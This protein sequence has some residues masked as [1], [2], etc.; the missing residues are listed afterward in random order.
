MIIL[1]TEIQS[2]FKEIAERLWMGHASIMVGAGFSK[3]SIN[4]VNPSKRPPDWAEL[5]DAFYEKLYN[6]KP[7]NGVKYLNLLKLSEEFEAAFGRPALEQFISKNIADNE[8][9]P[10][11]LHRMLIELPWTDVFTTNY[12]TLLE[13]SCKDVFSRKYDIV[14][15]QTDLVYS[16]KPRIIKLHG[17][18]PSEKPFIITE[19]DYRLYPKKYSP[20]VNTVQQSLLENTLCLIGFSGDDPNFLQWVGW[21]NDNIGKENAPKIYLVGVLN[22]SET[23]KKL[24]N[25]KNIIPVDISLCREINGD[26]K[27]GLE[28][29][30]NYLVNQQNKKENLEWPLLVDLKTIQSSTKKADVTLL[31]NEWAECRKKFP[32]WFILPQENRG[33]LWRYTERHSFNTSIFKHL[34]PFIELDY[35][36]ELNWRLE[37]CLFPIWNNLAPLFQEILNRYNFFPEKLLDKKEI[38]IDSWN[39][40]LIDEVKYKNYWIDLSLSLLRFYREEG[41][42]NEWDSIYKTLSLIVEHLSKEQIAHF[43]YERVLNY[44]FKMQYSEAKKLLDEW[45]QN[46][47]PV[48]WNAKRAMLMTEFG[49]PK[50]ALNLLELCLLQIRKKLNLSPIEEDYTWVSQESYVMLHLS[51]VHENIRWLEEK[52][53]NHKKEDF[54]ERWN[55]LLKYKCDPWGEK[56]YFDLVLGQPYILRNKE[57][58]RKEF[59]IGQI[60][61]TFSLGRASHETV[62]SYTFL[63]YL[64]ELAIPLSTEV[65]NFGSNT[66]N[67]ALERIKHVSPKWVMGVLNRHRDDKGVEVFFDRMQLKMLPLSLVDEYVKKYLYILNISLTESKSSHINR[68]FFNKIPFILSRLCTKCSESLR[69]EIFKSYAKLCEKGLVIR[70]M[71]ILLKNLVDSSTKSTLTAAIKI[72]FDVPV[73][74]SKDNPLHLIEP[75]TILDPENVGQKINIEKKKIEY[76]F[77]KASEISEYSSNSIIRLIFLFR[78]G[79]LNKKQVTR[80]FNIIWQNVDSSSGFPKETLFYNF[81]FIKWPHPQYLNVEKLFR[82]YINDNNFNIQSANLENGIEEISGNDK[83][84]EELLYSSKTMYHLDGIVWDLEDLEIILSKCEIWWDKDKQFLMKRKNVQDIYIGSQYEEFIK[85]FKNLTNILS[86]VIGYHRGKINNESIKRIELLVKDMEKFSIPVLKVKA[87][88]GLYKN[89]DTYLSVVSKA[90]ISNDRM[91]QV[92]ALDSIIHSIYYY[93]QSRDSKKINE[94]LTLLNAPLQWKIEIIIGDIFDIVGQIIIYTKVDISILEKNLYATLTDVLNMSKFSERIVFE[95]YLL[96]RRQA[97]ELASKLYQIHVNSNTT[98][99]NILFDWKTNSEDDNEFGDIK[100]RW[101]KYST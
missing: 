18:L 50:E 34:S 52:K 4:S 77:E 16:N 29:F 97:V 74:S 5:G 64:E 6:K 61:R 51:L 73:V 22:L 79:Q 21:I 95:D 69:I 68:A 46:N 14:I 56:K 94:I 58:A 89:I 70:K 99:P 25:K 81:A 13:R 63:R 67:G 60:T 88:F 98:P 48:L 27:K 36:F 80:L 83:Y 82:K 86:N 62:L 59:R 1:P 35:I 93:T 85:R 72:L 26:H 101:E 7:N 37:K 3:N 10:T 17:S 96:L 84:S 75:F 30:I 87:A 100:N 12:D 54:N 41:F 45:P 19:E 42:S 44:I 71:D 65:I 90:M 55:D 53:F 28:L 47:M 32:N 2:Y 24:L 57:I 39:G 9:E 43:Y 23:Q 31:V 15:N 8:Y 38:N 78:T 92:D 33:K 91:I 49:Q 11:H 40:D 20:F 76:I 66:I